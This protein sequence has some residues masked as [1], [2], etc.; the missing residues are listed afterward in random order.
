M[1][2][3]IKYFKGQKNKVKEQLNGLIHYKSTL[4]ASIDKSDYIYKRLLKEIKNLQDKI[5]Y[6]N[7]KIDFEKDKLQNYL[8]D[9]DDFYNYIRKK[10]QAKTD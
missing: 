10:R 5:E 9:K 6:Y 2:A 1:R 8:K 3:R 4:S 7:T